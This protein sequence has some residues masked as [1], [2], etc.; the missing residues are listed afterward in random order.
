[1]VES[2]HY[3]VVVLCQVMGVSR[4]AYYDWKKRPG[5]LIPAEELKMRRLMKECF[6]HSRESL[7]NRENDEET[8]WRRL[9]HWP[10]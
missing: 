10:V 8:G 6:E 3:P 5:K 2:E 1:M 4:S 9:C 7:G